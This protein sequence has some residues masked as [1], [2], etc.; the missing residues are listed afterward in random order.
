GGICSTTKSEL[1]FILGKA[2]MDST[3]YVEVV[4]QSYLVP[5]STN[6]IRNMDRHE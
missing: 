2:K 6:T 3:V 4:M 5:H 1:V